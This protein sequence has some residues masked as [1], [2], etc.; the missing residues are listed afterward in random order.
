ML[1]VTAVR[2]ISDRGAEIGSVIRLE[3]ILRN[4]QSNVSPSDNLGR[5]CTGWLVALETPL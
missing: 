5:V 2:V 3:V 4:L 1:G